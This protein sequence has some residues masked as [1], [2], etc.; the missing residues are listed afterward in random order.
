MCVFVLNKCF[1]HNNESTN[2]CN[3]RTLS[4]V[5]SVERKLVC[6][7]CMREIKSIDYTALILDGFAL[8][9]ISLK[10]V[11]SFK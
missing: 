2:N 10:I 9:F 11:R 3:T 5:S 7:E 4:F 8:N 1:L 6:S